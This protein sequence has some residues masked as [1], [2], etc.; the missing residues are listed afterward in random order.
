MTDIAQSILDAL[1]RRR[2]IAPVGDGRPGFGLDEAYAVADAILAARAARGERPAGWKIGFTN[3]AI[4]DEYGVRAPIWGPLYDSTVR[5]CDP[6]HETVELDADAFLEPRI[7]PEIVLRIARPPR[8]GMD[9]RELVSCIDAVAH[10]FEVVQSVYPGW[11]VSA[12]DT[13]AAAA[14]HGALVH[15][16][17]AA[18]DQARA[19][20]WMEQ[21]ESCDVT[22]FRDGEEVDRGTGRNV[23]GGP[24][25]ALRH[26][27]DGLAARP[28]A[29]GI[30]AGDLVSTG[31]VTRAFPVAAGEM[32]STR[33]EGLP[34][35]GLRLA[36]S[37]GAEAALARLIERAAEARFRFENPD[38]CASETD[39]QAAVAA[40][41]EA[42]AAISR[43]LLLDAGRLAE[44]RREVERRAQALAHD[45]RKARSAP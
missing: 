37:G 30:E 13:V 5:A 40:D 35:P 3:P 42:G 11:R 31:T 28:M 36:F 44:T 18:V 12:A 25:S 39:Y 14:M 20:E 7:E 23:L 32:W 21:L 2:Q 16:P 38:S 24:L 43:L 4:W 10:G 33:V 1:D 8:P 17:L 29:R 15:G 26:F 27:V 41:V 19:D 22:L 6:D 34:L 45:W 9:E